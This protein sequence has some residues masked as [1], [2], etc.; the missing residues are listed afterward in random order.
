MNCSEAGCSKRF[1][2]ENTKAE[3]PKE[4]TAIE[5]EEEKND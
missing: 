3:E 1:Y 4:E 5:K 2:D